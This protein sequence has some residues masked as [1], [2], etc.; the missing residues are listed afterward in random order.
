MSNPKS[1]GGMCEEPDYWEI[2]I[3][4]SKRDEEFVK[5]ARFALMAWLAFKYK[6]AKVLNGLL[7]MPSRS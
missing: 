5:R 6:K 4:Q 3:E 7:K 2:F 1:V